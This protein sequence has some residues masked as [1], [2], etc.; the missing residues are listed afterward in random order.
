M[1]RSAPQDRYD[2]K[3]SQPEREADAG[4]PSTRCWK[5]RRS[6]A[7]SA[8]WMAAFAHPMLFSKPGFDVDVTAHMVE[9]DE[10]ATQ[11]GAQQRATRN[12][13]TA[14]RGATPVQVCHVLLNVALRGRDT[15]RPQSMSTAQA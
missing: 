7:V 12:G 5:V 3:A 11:C 13:Q 1:C 6:C 15:M 10:A 9:N 4:E 8:C 14:S 2:T